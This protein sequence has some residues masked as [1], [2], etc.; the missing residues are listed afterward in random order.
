MKYMDARVLEPSP[1]YIDPRVLRTRHLLAESLERLLLE[2]PFDQ[3]SVSDIADGATLNRGTFYAHYPDKHALLECLVAN[4]FEAL[5]KRRGIAFDGG[6]TSAMRAIVLAVCDFLVEVPGGPG[7]RQMDQ[8]LEF[9]VVAVVREMILQGLRHYPAQ[10][11]CSPEIVAAAV[12]GAIF[13]AAKQW[14]G[15][16]DRDAADQA[17]GAITTLLSPILH[18]ST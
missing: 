12:A 16:P 8:H 2:K 4:R 7:A 9:A 6:C 5:L 13:G 18:T 11:G 10:N 1:G 14:L 17:A 3:I 15:T